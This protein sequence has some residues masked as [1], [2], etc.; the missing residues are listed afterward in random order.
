LGAVIAAAM[1]VLIVRGG[2][3]AFRWT[4]LLMLVAVVI[5]ATDGVLARAARVKEVLPSFDGRRLDDI[6]DFLTY[7]FL[8]L[9]LVW[10][11]GLLPAEHNAWLLLALVAS[12]YGFCQVEAKT[13]DG[14]FLGFPSYWNIVSF[15]LYL[16]HHFIAGWP[17]WL[18]TVLVAGLAGLTFVPSLYLYP[19]QGTTLRRTTNALAVVWACQIVAIWWLLP[20]GGSV[21][22][23]AGSLPTLILAS[24]AFPVYYLL[25]SWIVT[26]RIWSAARP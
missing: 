16:L 24:F 13:V 22:P 17:S 14:Y 25:A 8:P 11:A 19:T 20:T 21:E 15:Y 1:A 12:A 5:D 9:L 26:A 10:R 2:H 6:I 3:D 7:T 23:A 4:F 18:S